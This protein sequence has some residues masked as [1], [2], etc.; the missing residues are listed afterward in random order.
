M[1]LVCFWPLASVEVVVEPV[2]W[3]FAVVAKTRL[4]R[5]KPANA[6]ALTFGKKEPLFISKMTPSASR[7]DRAQAGFILNAPPDL[8]WRSGSRQ[9]EE[10]PGVLLGFARG[11]DR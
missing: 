11:E 6:A 1:T 5:A 9:F 7:N 2:T 4:A 10:F 3:A 8:C